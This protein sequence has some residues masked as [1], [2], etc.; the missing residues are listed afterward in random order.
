MTAPSA[1]RRAGGD[2]PHRRPAE[3]WLA[4][5]R[6]AFLTLASLAVLGLVSG[7]AHAQEVTATPPP[8]PGTGIGA[9]EPPPP[10]VLPKGKS[11]GRKKGGDKDGPKGS[12]AEGGSKAKG[13]SKGGR[14]EGRGKGAKTDRLQAS[15]GAFS[16]IQTYTTWGPALAYGKPVTV[17]YAA[18]RCSTPNG[19]ALDLSAQGSATVHDGL[20]VEAPALEVRPFSVT[21]TWRRPGNEAGWPPAWWAC[22][23]PFAQYTWEIPGTYTFRVSANDGV[24]ALDIATYGTTPQSVHWTHDG[25]A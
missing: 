5:T 3:R 16:H 7:S 4:A 20:S 19:R 13:R 12:K 23:L 24:W 22:D 2:R 18:D 1:P 17:S 14:A 25:C 6:V 11:G 9:A 15:C 8:L 10:P 21:G